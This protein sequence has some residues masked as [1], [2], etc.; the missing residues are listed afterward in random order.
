[1][2]NFLT[3]CAIATALSGCGYR[4]MDF[5]IVSSKNVTVPK[6]K[7][8]DRV[9]AEDCVPVVVIPF[10]MPNVKTAV[11]R[12]IEKAG[13]DFDALVDGVVNYDNRSFIFGQVCYVVEG[14]PISTRARGASFHDARGLI[15]SDRSAN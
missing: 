11:D 15:V 7:R 3:L 5:T 8:A 6:S 4:L 1:M 13:G 12:A 9:K 14:T 10:G 2:S